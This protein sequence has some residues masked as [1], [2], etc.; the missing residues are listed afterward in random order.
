MEIEK[1]LLEKIVRENIENQLK[2]YDFSNQIGEI[3]RDILRDKLELKVNKFINEKLKVEIQNI[4][5]GEIDTD[6]GWGK[7]EHWDSFEAMF[8]SKFYEKLNNTWRMKEVIGKIVEE[9]LDKLFKEKTKEMTEKIQDMV[10][11]E[12]LKEENK[13]GS[14]K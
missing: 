5:N 9:R 1:E 12:M 8:K 11:D 7:R 13:N 10:L 4:L 2:D 14:K 3:F 6:D